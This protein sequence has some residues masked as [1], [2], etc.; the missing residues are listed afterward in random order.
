V[1][2]KKAEQPGIFKKR[3][4]DLEAGLGGVGDVDGQAAAAAQQFQRGPPGSGV[5]S[6][7]ADLSG[8]LG[9]SAEDLGAFLAKEIRP[10]FHRFL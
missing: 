8:R 10:V 6:E 9:L 4:E 3:L 2:K 7:N 1:G 5:G